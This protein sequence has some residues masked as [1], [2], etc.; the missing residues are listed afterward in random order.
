MNI[1]ELIKNNK[2]TVILKYYGA[3]DMIS[4]FQIQTILD[5]YEEICSYYSNKDYRI[6]SIDDYVDYIFIESNSN[7]KEVI[8]IVRNDLKEKISKM[9]DKLIEYKEK[10]KQ[11]EVN[12]FIKNNYE[13]ILA[14]EKLKNYDY[15]A[16]EIVDYSLEYIESNYQCFKANIKLYKYIIKNYF[17]RVYYRFDKYLNVFYKYSELWE[18]LYSN[19]ILKEYLSNNNVQKLSLSL[20]YLKKA[21]IKL[22]K[23]SIDIVYNSIKERAFNSNDKEILNTYSDIKVTIKLFDS[24]GEF[25]LSDE[26]NKEL[27]KQQK[28]LDNYILKNGHHSKYE[29]N[30]EEFISK[31]EDLNINWEIKSLMLTHTKKENQMISRFQ[32]SIEG[33]EKRSLLDR[34][35]SGNEDTND[36]FPYSVQNHLSITMMVGRILINYMLSDDARRKEIM[37]YMFAGVVNYIEKNNI[38]ISNIEDDFNM[39]NY[40]IKCLISMEQQKEKDSLAL[41]YLNYNT[42]HLCIGI[43]EKILR[44]IC[45]KFIVVNR[46]IS[47]KN[48]SIDNILTSVEVEKYLG[49]ANIR[50]IRYYLTSYE[51]AGVKVGMNLRNDIC[52]YNNNIKEICTYENTLTV[53][54]LLL[55]VCNELLLK[56]IHKG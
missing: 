46:S 52:H 25:E 37:N 12:K 2:S 8:P 16:H 43:I 15:S 36:Y 56:V 14:L 5:N 48:L 49:T 26:F 35:V 13:K 9:L 29:I 47:T 54:Y 20:Q 31:Y 27:E 39:L 18:L 22:Y 30:L 19:K 32:Y 42:L 11:S 34:F 17:Y 40:S 33:I 1:I 3:K 44:E 45:Y 4:G 24:L 55:T 10:Y 38:D 21:D 50:T 23:N 51:S 28:V 41:V 53:I 6:I 7:L